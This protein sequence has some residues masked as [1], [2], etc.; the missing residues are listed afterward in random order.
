M[1][2]RSDILFLIVLCMLV[3]VIP[4]VFPFLAA[5]RLRLAPWA[6]AWFRMLPPAILASLLSVGLLFPGGIPLQSLFSPGI[7]AGCIAAAVSWKTRNII[8]TIV[9]GMLSYAALSGA[10]SEAF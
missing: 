6:V 9:A 5:H 2:V 4:R 10:M 3:T 8:F 1:T 7:A